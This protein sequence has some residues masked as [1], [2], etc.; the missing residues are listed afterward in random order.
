MVE[1]TRT[2]AKAAAKIISPTKIELVPQQKQK[3]QKKRQQQTKQQQQRNEIN[4]KNISDNNT[5]IFEK[6]KP[7]DVLYGRGKEAFE[8]IGN[9][10]FRLLISRYADAYQGSPT[11]KAKSQLILRIVDIVFSRGGRFLMRSNSASTSSNKEGREDT[12]ATNTST[13]NSRNISHNNSKEKVDAEECDDD[14]GGWIDGGKKMGKK[15]T[16]YALRDAVRGRVKCIF[17]KSPPSMMT[18]RGNDILPYDH[19]EIMTTPSKKDYYT[20]LNDNTFWYPQQPMISYDDEDESHPQ[21]RRNGYYRNPDNFNNNNHGANDDFMMGNRQQHQQQQQ[22]RIDRINPIVLSS[23][24]SNSAINNDRKITNTEEEPE[25]D[26]RSHKELD[27][28]IANDLMLFFSSSSSTSRSS[29][30]SSDHNNHDRY[31]SNNVKDSAR[32]YYHYNH[33]FINSEEKEKEAEN[34]DNNGEKPCGGRFCRLRCCRSIAIT[35]PPPYQHFH[36]NCNDN[37]PYNYCFPNP[38]NNNQQI[39]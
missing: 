35:P 5:L 10:C 36:P 28:E 11:K 27:N 32:K 19:R 38:A 37:H 33:Q 1:E 6:P 4:E 14:Q 31:H 20:L 22:E 2:V 16:G 26:W 17:E 23:I 9:D 39:Y 18:M 13:I 21:T 8:H 24:G 12:D 3:Q 15:K 30:I 25:K 7:A 29:I 34:S